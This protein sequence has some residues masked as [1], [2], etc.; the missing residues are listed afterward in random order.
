MDI[1]L[2][3]GCALTKDPHEQVSVRLTLQETHTI[4]EMVSS[5]FFL[6]RSDFVRGAVREKLA[7][8]RIETVRDVPRKQA[9]KEIQAY[10]KEHPV[11]YPSDMAA[12]LGLDLAMVMDIVK[13]FLKSG[14]AEEVETRGHA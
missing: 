4:D 8:L 13:D 12:A 1:K 9:E 3:E 10:L 2:Q 5:G 11:T 6:N 14:K 7:S